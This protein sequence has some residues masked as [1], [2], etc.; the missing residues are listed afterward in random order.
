MPPGAVR[1]K[2]NALS[3][4]GKRA[5]SD[6]V[7]QGSSPCGAS[8]HFCAIS[9]PWLP[10]L[11]AKADLAAFVTLHRNLAKLRG[12]VR[13]RGGFMQHGCIMRIGV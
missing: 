1:W 10:I 6:S 8:S 2:A 3:S 5:D 11:A 9:A 12:F 7:N 13:H 4:N